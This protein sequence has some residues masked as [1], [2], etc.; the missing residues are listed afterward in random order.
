MIY[1]YLTYC[2]QIWGATYN[3]YI[4]KLFLLQKRIIR[5]IC[6]VPRLTHTEPLFIE[7]NIMKVDDLYVYNVTLFM[8]K[9]NLNWL[10]N[11][12]STFVRFGEIHAINTRHFDLYLLPPCE[13]DLT[14]NFIHFLGP[15]AW[16]LIASQI[17]A[18]CSIG[19]FKSRLKKYISMNPHILEKLK[20]KP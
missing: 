1:P 19:V 13:S 20:K 15:K 3:K 16:N 2:I 8:Y 12:F 18:K 10:P 17:N 5:I 9:L 4:D 11:I 7:N 6:G 14:Y